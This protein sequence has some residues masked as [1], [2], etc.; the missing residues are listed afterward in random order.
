[1]AD[2][3]EVK[4]KDG[5]S[6]FDSQQA[7]VLPEPFA[8]TVS[9]SRGDYVFLPNPGLSRSTEE[10]VTHGNN[11][12]NYHTTKVEG[13]ERAG[14]GLNGEVQS[15]TVHLQGHSNGDPPAYSPMQFPTPPHG[16]TVQPTGYCSLP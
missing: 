5:P 16:D 2:Q 10:L 11:N 1:M 9:R 6:G 14:Q 3:Q 8:P 15:D 12:N 4:D 7:V 13:S